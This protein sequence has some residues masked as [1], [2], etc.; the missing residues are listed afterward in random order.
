MRKTLAA[1]DLPTTAPLSSLSVVA[2]QR[3]DDRNFHAPRLLRLRPIEGTGSRHRPHGQRWRRLHRHLHPAL[4]RRT[5]P[6]QRAVPLLDEH[7][8]QS[9]VAAIDGAAA[10]PTPRGHS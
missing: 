6:S 4:R 9:L 10:E 3:N 7:V 1:I 5:G 8:A 2:K